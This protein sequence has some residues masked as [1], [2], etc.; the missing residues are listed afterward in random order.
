MPKD[1]EKIIVPNMLRI[2]DKALWHPITSSVFSDSGCISFAITASANFSEILSNI[3]N[4]INLSADSGR[5]GQYPGP[6]QPKLAIS[7]TMRRAN[8]EERDSVKFMIF[9][10]V[11]PPVLNSFVFGI[12]KPER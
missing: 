12:I 3:Y 5:S 2:K 11:K 9:F 10:I 1:A 4:F 6:K 7:P 8:E